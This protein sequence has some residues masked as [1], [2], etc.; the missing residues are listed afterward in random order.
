M[1]REA[2]EDVSAG[3]AEGPE[4]AAMR[5]LDEAGNKTY[6]MVTAY[7]MAGGSPAVPFVRKFC[8]EWEIDFDRFV[9]SMSSGKR[10]DAETKLRRSG[11]IP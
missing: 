6:L 5:K 2:P 10:E 4:E 11:L 1:L 7:L 8:R 3:L 9:D